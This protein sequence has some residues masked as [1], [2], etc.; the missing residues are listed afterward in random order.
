MCPTTDTQQVYAA[1]VNCSQ[2]CQ[3]SNGVAYLHNCSVGL[4]FNPK[5]NICDWPF[6]AGCIEDKNVIDI[7]VSDNENSEP[8]CGN[9]DPCL[10]SGIGM[11]ER[12]VTL[13]QYSGSF[14]RMSYC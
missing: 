9:E 10:E 7:K 11:I 3:C 6:I 14:R 13:Y 1:L 2:F 5:L 8:D 4:H 12:I